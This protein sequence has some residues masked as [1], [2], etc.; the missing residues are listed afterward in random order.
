MN[1]FD[2]LKD[3]LTRLD[4]EKVDYALCGGLAMA[5]H[6]FPRSTLD[7]DIMIDRQDLEKVKSIAWDLGFVLDAGLMSFREGKVRIYRVTKIEKDSGETL[8]LDL[9]LVTETTSDAWNTRT[10]MEW[11]QGQLSVVS[12]KG[13]IQLKSM[14][15]SGQDEDDIKHLRSIM[16]ED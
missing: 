4:S 7:I 5:V 6:A 8:V 2:E 13:L 10:R 14:R 12:A 16:D 1:L 11:D 9:L 15:R 3:I